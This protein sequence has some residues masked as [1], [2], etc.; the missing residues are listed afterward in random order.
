MAKEVFE[1]QSGIITRCQNGKCDECRIGRE[2]EECKA[3][4]LRL[5]FGHSEEPEK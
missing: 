4:L 1:M 3:E 5:L 2:A